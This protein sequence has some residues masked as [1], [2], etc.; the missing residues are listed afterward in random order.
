MNKRCN[1]ISL[2]DLILN[3]APLLKIGNL[4]TYCNEKAM[5]INL[6]HRNS[7]RSSVTRA[8]KHKKDNQSEH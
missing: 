5:S 7:F 1:K 2:S 6:M 3:S 8:L 4:A